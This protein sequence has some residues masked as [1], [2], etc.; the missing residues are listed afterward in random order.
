MN[1][2]GLRGGIYQPLSPEGIETIHQASLAILEKTG[3]AYE[4]GLDE[5]VAMLA[6]AGAIVD[7]GTQRIRFPKKMIPEQIAKAPLRVILY[8][9]DGQNDLD[10]TEDKV[11]LGTGGAAVKI[12]DLESGKPRPS[13]LKDI[14]A[15]GRLVDKLEHIHFFLR[16]C[17]PTDIPEEDYDI[18]MFYAG[19]KATGK[20]V[21]SGVND[22]AGLQH[23]D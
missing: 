21:M 11:H 8:A 22:E 14:Y 3:L 1:L 12:L 10:L 18:N 17:I 19:L 23:V 13:T 16:P 7:H 15:I 2:K 4:A 5:T 9:R 20:H 6:N